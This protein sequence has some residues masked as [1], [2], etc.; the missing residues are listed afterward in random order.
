VSCQ[1][2][3]F[4]LDGTLLDTIGDIAD[5]M[6]QVLAKHGYP[7]HTVAEY[8]Q[9]VGLGMERLVYDSLPESARKPEIIKRVLSEADAAYSTNWKNKTK[10]YP[11]VPELLLQLKA[12]G[13]KTAVLSNKP[14]KFTQ[15]C[16]QALLPTK[17]LDVVLGAQKDLALKPAPDGALKIASLLGVAPENVI[18]VGDTGTDMLTAKAANMRAVGVSWGFRTPQELWEGG[19]SAVIQR[20]E[21]LLGML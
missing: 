4:D 21:E 15:V 12:R 17:S 18:Y 19:A 2:V 3:I 8:Q 7:M 9:L 16:V 10:P 6:N 11:G 5:A 20:P 1:A 14:Q 13:V